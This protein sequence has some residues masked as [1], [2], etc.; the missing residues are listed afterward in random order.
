MGFDLLMF[1][2]RVGMNR[3]AAAPR[4][5]RNNVPHARGDE[6]EAAPIR[7]RRG[8]ESFGEKKIEE[9]HGAE[10]RAAGYRDAAAFVEDITENYTAIYE[11]RDSTLLLMKKN[12]KTKVAF[13][14][15]TLGKDK[16]FYDVSSATLARKKYLDNKKVLWEGANFLHRIAATPN[17]V[18]GQSENRI[19]KET[20]E[21]KEKIQYV[22]SHNRNVLFLP[23]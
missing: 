5:F 14:S 2:T 16:T 17:A 10:I 9:K 19:K 15:L 7:L 22:S 4:L 6:P 8:D 11:G 23:K 18:S 20:G 1:P 13:I 12:G 21:V 3:P